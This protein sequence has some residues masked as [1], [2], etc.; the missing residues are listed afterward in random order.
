[1][2]AIRPSTTKPLTTSRATPTTVSA[3][4]PG[5]SSTGRPSA[6]SMLMV[7]PIG[8]SFGQNSRAVAALTTATRAAALA[9]SARKA[10]A[11]VN[12]NL[13]QRKVFRRHE[14]VARAVR[15]PLHRRRRGESRERMNRGLLGA[16]R[17]H[18]AMRGSPRR[19][20]ASRPAGDASS[21][22]TLIESTP[23]RSVAEIDPGDRRAVARQR[24]RQDHQDRADGD[25]AADQQAAEPRAAHAPAP[26]P[27]STSISVSRDA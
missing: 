17:R 6:G 14:R 16:R 26:W 15:R 4:Y 8:S 20:S 24:H 7:L 9:S 10:A 21:P 27:R 22:R 25:L 3:E 19:T 5:R 18:S 2:A 13:Q 1:M 23:A 12:R 11:A